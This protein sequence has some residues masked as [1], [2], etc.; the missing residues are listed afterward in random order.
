MKILKP[1]LENS[2]F[3]HAR[4]NTD[5]RNFYHK[6]W[7]LIHFFEKFFQIYFICLY[8]LQFF[9]DWYKNVNL[10]V[11]DFKER[12]CWTNVMRLGWLTNIMADSKR[13]RQYQKQNVYFSYFTQSITSSCIFW[14]Y[15]LQWTGDCTSFLMQTKIDSKMADSRWPQINIWHRSTSRSRSAAEGKPTCIQYFRFTASKWARIS[16]KL[17]CSFSIGREHEGNKGGYV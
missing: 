3:E 1:D 17:S 9:T 12:I 6:N 2:D 5:I 10:C 8:R 13:P 14:C 16:Y 11:M 7:I 4:K 15:R